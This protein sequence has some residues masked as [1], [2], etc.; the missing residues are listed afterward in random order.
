MFN[1]DVRKV[2]SI[3]NLRG[4]LVFA[5]PGSLTGNQAQGFHYGAPFTREL[6]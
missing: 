6:S 3:E 2:E 1:G 4:M 5:V